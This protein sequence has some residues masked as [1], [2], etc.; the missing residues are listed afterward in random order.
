MAKKDCSA[1]VKFSRI[2]TFEMHLTYYHKITKSMSVVTSRL[3]TKVKAAMTLV[4]NF[5]NVMTSSLFNLRFGDLKQCKL[6]IAD[7]FMKSKQTQSLLFDF[8]VA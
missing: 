4:N 7:R 8:S 2:N 1:L 6:N 5:S 3:L